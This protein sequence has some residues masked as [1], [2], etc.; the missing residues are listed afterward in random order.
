MTRIHLKLTFKLGSS[1]FLILMLTL[2]LFS[3]PFIASLQEFAHDHE[4]EAPQ[5]V[6]NIS[7]VLTPS[8]PNIVVSG[9]VSLLVV[10]LVTTGISVLL[11]HL[12]NRAT[13]SRAPP[14]PYLH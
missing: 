2:G 12:P 9:E 7:A 1:I 5:H 13:R 8:L 14:L 4:E 11:A 10:I 3:A 6:H